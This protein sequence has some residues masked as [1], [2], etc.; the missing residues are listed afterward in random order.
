MNRRTIF[1]SGMTIVTVSIFFG[2]GHMIGNE[3]VFAF[4]GV[5]HGFLGHGFGHFYGPGFGYSYDP[6][7][8]IDNPCGGGPYSIIDGQAVCT[9]G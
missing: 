9:I 5:G 2:S 1:Y 7:Y 4:G 8:V 3:K 6:G